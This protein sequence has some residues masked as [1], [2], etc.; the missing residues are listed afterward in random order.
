MTLSTDALLHMRPGRKRMARARG[1]DGRSDG[2]LPAAV[3]ATA[4]AYRIRHGADPE[5][6]L[7]EDYGS[8]I[9]QLRLERSI[10]DNQLW[11]AQAYAQCVI[12]NAR[13]YGIPSPHPRA[14]DLASP[15]K[16]QSCAPESDTAVIDEIKGRFRN[17]R[18]ALLD[19]GRDMLVGSAINRIVYGVV[20]EDWPRERLQREDVQN[21]R[22]GLN[23]L[24]RVLK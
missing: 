6:A 4:K 19:C 22:C 23:V 20:I 9:G 18:R 11:A 2:E 21:L 1:S 14:L 8:T 16:G 5:I 10:S 3:T 24:A 17:C 13:L 12:S 7:H 15:F